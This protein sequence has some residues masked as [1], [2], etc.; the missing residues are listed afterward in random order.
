MDCTNL[1]D[2]DG[3]DL[4]RELKRQNE[5]PITFLMT[6]HATKEKTIKVLNESGGNFLFKPF[7]IDRLKKVLAT[8]LTV[9]GQSQSTPECYQ[10][11]S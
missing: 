7:D 1:P 2:G 5:A 8:R 6:A 3:V 10:D 4:F 9:V 11:Q